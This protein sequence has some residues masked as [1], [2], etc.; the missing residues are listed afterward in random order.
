[1]YPQ[2]RSFALLLTAAIT[3]SASLFAYKWEEIDPAD[4]TLEKSTIDPEASIEILFSEVEVAQY[5][6][7][8]SMR[9]SRRVRLRMKAFDENG[10]KDLTRWE[11]PL[12]EDSWLDDIEARTIKSDGRII[13]LDKSTI[14]DTE[15]ERSSRGKIKAKAFAFP[16]LE[17]GDIVDLY[18]ELKSRGGDWWSFFSFDFEY[19][20]RKSTFRIKPAEPDQFPF[21]HQIVWFNFPEADGK[22]KGGFYDFTRYNE[23]GYPNESFRVP[24]IQTR[25]TIV[26]YYIFE[27]PPSQKKFW[28]D[29]GKE[30]MTK[31]R[32]DFK[33]GGAMKKKVDELI[34]G[35][36]SDEEKLRRLYSYC[37]DEVKNRSYD[38]GEFSQTEQDEM[39]KN[40]SANDTFNNGYGWPYDIRRLFG[41][42][43]REAG[44]EARWMGIAD[45]QDL[46]FSPNYKY[47]FVLSDRMVAVQLGGDW[48]FF[49][50]GNPCLP[51]GTL[52]AGYS[53]IDGLVADP[54]KE[55]FVHTPSLDHTQSTVNRESKFKVDENGTLSGSVETR[56]TGY[57]AVQKRQE[58]ESK[59]K[60]EREKMVRNE[61]SD[62]LP[63]AS[64]SE[65]RFENEREP[66]Q[67]LVLS[68]EL[69]V[70]EY[71]EV[72]GQRMFVQ[73]SVFNRGK[74]A[75]FKEETRKTDVMFP[76]PGTRSEKL[77]MRLPDGYEVETGQSPEPF[78]VDGICSYNAAIA[79]ANGK[80]FFQ[81]TRSFSIQHCLFPAKA[82]ELFNKVYA[83]MQVQDGYALTFR[84]TAEET[85][86]VE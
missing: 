3:Y 73:P 51:F 54:K 78:A 43:A 69:E 57:Y 86:S 9:T 40:E 67:D 16:D 72:A 23:P 61:V 45:K 5:Y 19:P 71:A 77:T 46:L 37:T 83:T 52:A 55:T 6:I 75:L 81:Y 79:M 44:F 85:A 18:V 62:V 30:Y 49:D 53:D 74:D 48:K 38:W 32:Q 63:R 1:M 11:I 82:G 4:F 66:D 13:D 35:A 14:Y 39:K 47:P 8:W 28:V 21:T 36:G 24:D 7:D 27:E 33:G 12:V 22:S 34:S 31:T 20:S 56:Y 2:I 29:T 59:T 84:K 80:P 58:L 41:A 60:E 42:M 17:A 10:V 25:P 64:L 68:Y 50:P 15:V 76:F 26:V 65:I 70:P